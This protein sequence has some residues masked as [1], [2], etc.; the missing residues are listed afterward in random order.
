[1]RSFL[2]CTTFP[3]FPDV[4]QFVYLAHATI[5]IPM[6]NSAKTAISNQIKLCS[7]F[8]CG[9]RGASRP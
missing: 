7:L 9:A 6:K 1:M 4:S 8:R 3:A 5:V 2:R